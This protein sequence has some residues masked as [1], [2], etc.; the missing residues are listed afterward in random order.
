M[1]IHFPR[2]SDEWRLVAASVRDTLQRH[3]GTTVSALPAD[4]LTPYTASSA[5][6]PP[7]DFAL[8]VLDWSAHTQEQAAYEA[9]VA[10]DLPD[11]P[12]SSY[13]A[14]HVKAWAS[15]QNARLRAIPLLHVERKL[16]HKGRSALAPG[17]EI[18]R[19]SDS[20]V[21]K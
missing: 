14:G 13:F 11:L 4:G 8:V 7:W 2:G 20:W 1:L 16:F 17:V 5:R 12:P 3:F 21:I 6:R 18:P 15:K 10:L 19:L 9:M